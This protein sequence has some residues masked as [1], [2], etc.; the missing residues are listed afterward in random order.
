[1][2]AKE[3]KDKTITHRV[4]LGEALTGPAFGDTSL[5][6]L[7]VWMKQRKGTHCPA[8]DQSAA[9]PGEWIEKKRIATEWVI[10]LSNR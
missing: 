5:S 2:L 4:R 3:S 8:H 7:N 1:M 10:S 9:G 6:V